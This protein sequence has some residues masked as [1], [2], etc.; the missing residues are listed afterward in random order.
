MLMY[1]EA[2]CECDGALYS[3]A[4]FVVDLPTIVLFYFTRSIWTGP[5]VAV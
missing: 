5:G 4:V 1:L 3:Q 2:L